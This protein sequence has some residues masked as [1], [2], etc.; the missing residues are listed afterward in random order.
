MATAVVSTGFSQEAFDAFLAARDEPAWLTDMR[1]EAWQRFQELPMPSVRDEEWMRTDIR[2]FK[3]DRFSLPG[4]V[5]M[6]RR[7]RATALPHA[8]LAAGVDLGGRAVSIEQPSVVRP[9]LMPKLAEQGVLFGSLDALVARAWRSAAA[10]FRAAR[11]RSVQGQVLRAARGL[12]VRRHAAVCA[13]E[14]A[15]R[16]AAAFAVGDGRRRRRPRQDAGDSRAEG[17]EATML[18]ETASTSPMAAACIAARSS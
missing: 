3:L 5:A 17:A 12:L 7:H 1:R 4:H 6:A 10:V 11:R 18:S 15:H 8:L 9:S 14:R 16:A 2:L 13:Q